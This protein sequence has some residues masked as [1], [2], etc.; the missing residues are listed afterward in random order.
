[1]DGKQSP[2]L[3]ATPYNSHSGTASM[4]IGQCATL[5]HQMDASPNNS[6]F[7]TSQM[8]TDFPTILRRRRNLMITAP[9]A[10]SKEADRD[11]HGYSK[12]ESKSQILLQIFKELA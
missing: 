3:S 7:Q 8:A 4:A 1:M 5:T 9:T 6:P 10:N 12:I 11:V 2:V